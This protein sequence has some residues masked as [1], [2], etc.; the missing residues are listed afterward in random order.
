M[1]EIVEKGSSLDHQEDITV[2]AQKGH[3][4][5]DKY[6]RPLVEIDKAVERRLRWKACLPF[7]RAQGS[8]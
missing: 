1:S 4:A 6:G 3:V 8:V 2:V 7:R 5:T